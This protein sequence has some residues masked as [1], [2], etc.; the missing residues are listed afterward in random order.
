M[1]FAVVGTGFGE[2]HVRWITD[3]PG[4]AVTVLC[5]REDKAKAARIAQQFNIPRIDPDPLSVLRSGDVDAVCVVTPP[6][7][8][9]ELL[10][11]GLDA[12]LTAISDKPL[13]ADVDTANRLAQHAER[14]QADAFVTFQWRANRALRRIGQLQRDGLFG[15]VRQVSLEFHHSFLGQTKTPWPWR[16]DGRSAGAGTL[17]DQGVHLFDALRWLLGEEW[18]VDDARSSITFARR[19]HQDQSLDGGAEDIADVWLSSASGIPARVFTSRVSVHRQLRVEIHGSRAGVSASLDPDD[20]SGRLHIFKPDSD[21]QVEDF[22]ADPMNIYK[23]F[24]S[25]RDE[26]IGAP[27]FADGT[28]AQSLMDEAVRRFRKTERP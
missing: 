5:Y 18:V 27:T 14:R 25:N 1:R 23:L 9:N 24:F 19:L 26:L 20:G 16:H 6:E 4:M 11:A 2:Q 7:T 12:G 28:R 21:P 13:A 8:H 15:R 22:P 3:I 17:S 10:V